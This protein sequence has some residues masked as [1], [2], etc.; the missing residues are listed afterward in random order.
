MTSSMFPHLVPLMRVARQWRQLKTMKWHGF[1]HGSDSPTAGD[2]TLFCPACPQP[3]IN[4]SLSGDESLDDWK[5]TWSFVMDGNFKAEHL[6][7]I[8]PLDEV[9]KMH[10]AVASDMVE[11][12]S[13]NNHRCCIREVACA[14]HGCF[15]PHFMVNFQEGKRQDTHD[16]P[17]CQ[18]NHTSLADK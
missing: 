7:P 2:L 12:L 9:Y 13:C 17:H 11:K 4:V 5:Y 16:I 18:I 1:G 15:V 14:R 10:L 3:G 8:K 6:H